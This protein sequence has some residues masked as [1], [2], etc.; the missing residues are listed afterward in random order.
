MSVPPL[1]SFCYSASTKFLLFFISAVLAVHWQMHVCQPRPPGQCEVWTA[2][3]LTV[4][5][6]QEETILLSDSAVSHVLIFRSASSW[7]T[8][9]TMG[10]TAWD[11]TLLRAWSS[12][13]SAGPTFACRHCPQSSLQR[14]TLKS[15]LR[16]RIPC[17]RWENCSNHSSW[18]SSSYVPYLKQRNWWSHTQHRVV[19]HE[20]FRFNLCGFR[21][22][23][24]G[25][26][27]MV[28]A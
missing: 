3:S 6:S 20:G 14:S 21:L 1:L 25:K 4:Q 19:M 5:S 22:E 28:W 13:C 11:C 2:S 16:R 7:P 15:F 23:V 9:L 8:C 18:F 12:L 27:V 24:E 10:M 26:G 17:G